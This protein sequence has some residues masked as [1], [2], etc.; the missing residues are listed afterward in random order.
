MEN[1]YEEE[2]QI[3]SVPQIRYQIEGPTRSRMYN[4]FIYIMSNPKR[5]V[6]LSLA[7]SGILLYVF[8][9]YPLFISFILNVLSTL[10]FAYSFFF[11]ISVYYTF[12]TIQKFC[13]TFIRNSVMCGII[14]LFVFHITTTF[15]VGYYRL[16]THSQIIL[17]KNI[18][19]F[20]TQLRNF[21]N[22]TFI[23]LQTLLQEY[24][25]D[26]QTNPKL[27]I[28]FIHDLRL[29]MNKTFA[30]GASFILF[31]HLYLS[32][33]MQ[34]LDVVTAFFGSLRE[35]ISNT[36]DK[37]F[38]D[39]FEQS[40]KD[41]KNEVQK[42]TVNKIEEYTRAFLSTIYSYVGSDIIVTT[43]DEEKEH[44]D[45]IKK[46]N[47]VKND[48]GKFDEEFKNIIDNILE[49]SIQVKSNIEKARTQEDKNI[50]VKEL[51]QLNKVSEKSLIYIAQIEKA[52]D[53]KN[54]ITNFIS[55]VQLAVKSFDK[56]NIT[57]YEFI[58]GL[59]CQTGH[60][61]NDT[62]IEFKKVLKHDINFQ[63]D[64]PITS[65]GKIIKWFD[66]SK[67]LSNF[68][69]KGDDPFQTLRDGGEKILNEFLLDLQSSPFIQ[70]TKFLKHFIN[71]RK[72][73]NF[74][75]KFSFNYN[76][77]LEE[78]Y[79]TLSADRYLLL[80][81]LQQTFTFKTQLLKSG[82]QVGKNIVGSV[83][84]VIEGVE[85]ATGLKILDVK[86]I[87]RNTYKFQKTLEEYQ[88]KFSQKLS[89]NTRK[90]ANNYASG[91]VPE[92]II[93]D[94]CITLIAQPINRLDD[95]ISVSIV[96]PSISVLFMVIIIILGIFKKCKSSCRT[97]RQQY[98]F[99]DGEVD[100]NNE[101]DVLIRLNDIFY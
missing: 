52:R 37:L 96:L 12:P 34:N 85:E 21:V 2:K 74:I 76:M 46:I 101:K 28:D 45:L 75:T 99:E 20:S 9:D 73:E 90:L 26:A 100:D 27:A 80:K 8:R 63:E 91:F 10:D 13:K 11:I 30:D 7:V 62:I 82:E 58:G 97:L 49:R 79:T 61:I 50:L 70:Q 78:V 67:A 29:V 64:T 57:F 93:K 53:V 68:V 39:D 83:A 87:E 65:G 23:D 25:F 94:D 6:S 19:I 43:T 88:L 92:C 24:I 17:S 86:E 84:G 89:E 77:L 22:K 5:F 60:I 54:S 59:D 51:N 47:N 98:R 66:Y 14:M 15:F 32:S 55:E 56:F 42:T 31:S 38:V 35:Q 1:L 4:L 16:I 81:D 71:D 33:N 40:Y 48:K 18:A 44:E 36:D 69:L 3:I 72:F 41:I 95:P